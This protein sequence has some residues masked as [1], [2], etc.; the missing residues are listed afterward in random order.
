MPPAHASITSQFDLC[1][2]SH[3]RSQYRDRTGLQIARTVEFIAA[4]PS[5]ITTQVARNV[6]APGQQTSVTATLRDTLNNP[7]KN[8]TV[9]FTLPADD[10]NGSLSAATAVSHC[11]MARRP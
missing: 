1:R 5:V 11:R 8:K 4:T 9:N 3:Y 10:S 7:V 2:P 6:L